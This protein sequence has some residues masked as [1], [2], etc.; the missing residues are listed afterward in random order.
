M[1][2]DQAGDQSLKKSH[3]DTTLEGRSF[4]LCSLCNIQTIRGEIEG[5]I[6]ADAI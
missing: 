2:F 4:A 5:A 3:R 6:V 1:R